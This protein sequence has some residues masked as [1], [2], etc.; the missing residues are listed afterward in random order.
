MKEVRKYLRKCEKCGQKLLKNGVECGKQRWRCLR[1]GTS[2]IRKREDVTKRNQE[3]TYKNYLLRKETANDIAKR[4]GVSR[5]TFSRRYASYVT[6]NDEDEAS[7]KTIF[8]AYHPY[9]IIDATNLNCEVV[10]IVRGQKYVLTW[11]FSMYE[12]SSLWEMTLY[13]FNKPGGIVSDGQK[14]VLKA[15]YNLWGED[16]VL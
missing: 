9:L 15:L 3:N 13:R 8:A 6:L 14:G 16:I 11:A 2:R 1:C 10:A 4:R 12:S 7:S 5:R